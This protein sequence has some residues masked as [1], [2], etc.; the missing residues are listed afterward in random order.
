MRIPNRKG[1]AKVQHLGITGINI[2][3]VVLMNHLC[4][5]IYKGGFQIA[6]SVAR[7][8]SGLTVGGDLR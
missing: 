8:T 5:C 6:G 3:N 4:L 1:K 2:A 7:I